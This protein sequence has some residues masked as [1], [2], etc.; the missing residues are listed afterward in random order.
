[1]W[2]PSQCCDALWFTNIEVALAKVASG[3]KFLLGCG[4]EERLKASSFYGFLLLLILVCYNSNIGGFVISLKTQ[5]LLAKAGLS[6]D[7]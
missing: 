7:I 4:W 1:M 5:S 6:G 3:S 2:A